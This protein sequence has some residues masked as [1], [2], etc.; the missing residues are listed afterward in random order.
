MDCLEDFGRDEPVSVLVIYQ[1]SGGD[2][3]WKT[4]QTKHSHFIGMLE[5][6]K[7]YYLESRRIKE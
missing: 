2:L 4:D 5:M 3:V 7:F 6:T 1:T